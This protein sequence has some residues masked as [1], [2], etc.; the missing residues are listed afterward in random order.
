[1]RHLGPGTGDAHRPFQDNL[2][3][4]SWDRWDILGLG[5]HGDAHRPF[6]G[7]PG[8]TKVAIVLGQMGHLSPRIGDAHRPCQGQHGMSKLQHSIVFMCCWCFHQL[9]F[10]SLLQK[11]PNLIRPKQMPKGLLRA[12]GDV[13]RRARQILSPTFS[14][15]KMKMVSPAG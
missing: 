15:N 1:M 3:G 2:H 5:L 14:A 11:F 8:M 6:Q 4:M 9:M 10:V 7:Q 13:W 12:E